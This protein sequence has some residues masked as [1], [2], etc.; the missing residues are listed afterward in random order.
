MVSWSLLPKEGCCELIITTLPKRG[1]IWFNCSNYW[2]FIRFWLPLTKCSGIKSRSVRGGL[3]TDHMQSPLA[4]I[5]DEGLIA[6][7]TSLLV[8]ERGA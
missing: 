6:R 5:F 3:I 8:I 7:L 1:V 2:L 4:V